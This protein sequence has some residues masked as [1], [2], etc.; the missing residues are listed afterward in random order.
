MNSKNI[1]TVI[2]IIAV[3]GFSTATA[4]VVHHNDTTKN[5]QAMMASDAMQKK[6]VSKAATDAAMKQAETD[7]MAAH[8]AMMH[9]T[10][11]STTPAGQ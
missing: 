4:L 11:T 7:K 3:I 1:Q 8:D 5:S 9:Q 10:T 2:A 6:E